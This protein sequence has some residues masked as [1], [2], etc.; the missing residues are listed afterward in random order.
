M[1]SRYDSL[2]HNLFENIDVP[3]EPIRNTFNH[4]LFNIPTSIQHT[5]NALNQIGGGIF[6]EEPETDTKTKTKAKTKC[7]NVNKSFIKSCKTQPI[8]ITYKQPC[9]QIGGFYIS[10]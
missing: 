1:T 8:N 6:Y 4:T 3:L 7:E 5:D 9:I 2:V 10:C